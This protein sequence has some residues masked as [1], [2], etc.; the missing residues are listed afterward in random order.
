MHAHA[1]LPLRSGGD[2]N[3]ETLLIYRDLTGRKANWCA[4]RIIALRLRITVLTSP[5]QT[6][7]APIILSYSG[8]DKG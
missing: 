4:K 2:E 6:C 7:Y 5:W 8:A 3:E 1:S